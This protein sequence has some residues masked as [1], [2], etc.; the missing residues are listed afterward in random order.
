MTERVE[1][2]A[3]YEPGRFYRREL[4]AL[5]SIIAKLRVYPEAILID[6]LAGRLE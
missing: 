6:G 4:P 3:P 5:L 1:D 2:P